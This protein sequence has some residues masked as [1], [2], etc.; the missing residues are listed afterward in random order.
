[1]RA[2]L[3]RVVGAL[4]G[5]PDLDAVLVGSGHGALGL[6]ERV[7]GERGGES[8]RHRVGGLGERLRGVAARDVAALADVVLEL[9]GVAERK[10]AVVDARRA[11]GLGLLDG[12]DGLEL[13]VLN[14]DELLGLLE[15]LCVL[16]HDEC[17]GVSQAARDVALGDHDVPVLDEVAHLVV[18]HVLG[19][20][21]A[22]DAGKRLGLARVDGENAGARILGAHRGGV[23]QAGEVC[24][25]HVVGVLAKAQHLAADVNAEDLLAHGVVVAALGG[26]VDLLVAAKDGGGLLDAHEDALVAGAA[27]DVALD[28]L[29]DLQ[30]GG[31][32]RAAAQGGACHDH[33]RDAEAAL[34]GAGGAERVDER[35]LLALGEALDRHD[36]VA[37]GELRGEH[38][39]LHGL[40]VDDD[41]A[42]A[43]GAIRAAVLDA[44]E[45]EVIAQVAQDRLVLGRDEVAAVDMQRVLGSHVLPPLPLGHDAER[46]ADD[47][48]RTLRSAHAAGDAVRPVDNG[49]VV[50]HVD[51][52][53]R[54]G[55]LAG[56]AGNAAV[57]ALEAGV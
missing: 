7:L 21:H 26:R 1:M 3:A 53:G 57:V 24:L 39:R 31:V 25:G 55:T 5:G 54:A 12:A 42:R 27:A 19:R 50:C 51:G 43:A 32:G 16:G 45:V 37:L 38:A 6:E 29:G 8:L 34:H 41:R 48:S 18:G 35:L 13:L 46:I 52:A 17:D 23:A 20:E 30:V 44:R 40:V 2:L 36:V 15:G 28:G 49:M 14:L 47:V 4:V 9:D 33:A 22:H 56:T 11:G 10:E